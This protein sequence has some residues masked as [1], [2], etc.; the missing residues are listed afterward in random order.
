MWWWHTPF[1]PALERQRPRYL[2]EFETSL[3]YRNNSRTARIHKESLSHLPTPG[4]P[5]KNNTE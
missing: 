3:V 1:I 5:A 2:C 4:N